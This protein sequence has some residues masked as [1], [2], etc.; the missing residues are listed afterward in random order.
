[1][2]FNPRL[3]SFA[4]GAAA[5]LLIA[6]GASEALAASPQSLGGVVLEEVRPRIITPN[7]DLRNDAVVFQFDSSLAGIPIEA[8]ILDIHGARVAGIE[9]GSSG[10]D[11]DSYL[12]WDGRDESGRTMPSGVYI[13]SIKIGKSAATGTV[14][15]AR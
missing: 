4:L 7:G 10:L 3:T 15:V 14:V 2:T 5:A 1:M 13:Y 6:A 11:P 12:V 8:N 9:L